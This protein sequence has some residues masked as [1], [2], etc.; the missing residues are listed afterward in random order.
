MG[1][2]EEP[3]AQPIE[4]RIFYISHKSVTRDNATST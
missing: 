3:P 2:T 4:S 1:I